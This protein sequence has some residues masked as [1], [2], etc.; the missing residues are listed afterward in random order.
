[1]RLGLAYPPSGELERGL[2]IIGDA[3]D[4]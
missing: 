3:L 1:M 2:E 4:S